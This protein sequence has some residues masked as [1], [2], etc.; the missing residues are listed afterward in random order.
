MLADRL[1]LSA[2]VPRAR[3]SVEWS[4]FCDLRVWPSVRALCSAREIERERDH[5][6]LRQ[7]T[8]IQTELGDCKPI[9][10]GRSERKRSDC[11]ALAAPSL[12]LP[13]QTH[14]HGAQ[15]THCSRPRRSDPAHPPRR[16]PE[17]ESS[18]SESA[19]TPFLAR[20]LRLNDSP[21]PPDGRTRSCAPSEV[22]LGSAR[23]VLRVPDSSPSASSHRLRASLS[24]LSGGTFSGVGRCTGSLSLQQGPHERAGW[25]EAGARGYRG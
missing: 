14:S 6:V 23:A 21:A 1:H 20:A 5:V 24:S 19:S 16:A 2:P 13:V 22:R 18:H 17:A 4:S 12:T 11:A 8:R 3:V 9:R 25:A 10:G 15:Q 7:Y